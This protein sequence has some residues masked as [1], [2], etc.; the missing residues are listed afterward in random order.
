[1][2]LPG[3]QSLVV[4]PDGLS[5]ATLRASGAGWPQEELSLGPTPTLTL[6]NATENERLLILERMVWTDQ[7]TTAAE[8]IT[9]QRFRD[10]FSREIL[11]PG[12][13][14]SVGS[15]AV[16][17]TDLRGSTRLYREIG[18]APAFGRVMSH[19]DVL[20]QAIAAEDGALVKTIG[21]AVMAVFRSPLAALRAVLGAQ[22]ALA[23]PS[24]GERPLHLKAGIHY[25]PSIAV[26]LNDRLDYFGATVNIAARLVGLS[27]GD[28]VVV[29]AAVRDDPEVADWLSLTNG[30]LSVEPIQATLKG[31][32]AER[33][34]LWRV[35]PLPTAA[36]QTEH[37]G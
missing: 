13:E 8:V 3:G 11:R 10:L 2:E 9:L 36:S 24:G 6:E 30:S 20:R 7:A 23:S 14:V 26:T 12:Q 15:L 29:S 22:H 5:E 4:E 28:D 37:E 32:D 25:G 18:D 21:D 16:V 19:F 31:F 27:S 33:F 34:D 17:F 35:R 1:L